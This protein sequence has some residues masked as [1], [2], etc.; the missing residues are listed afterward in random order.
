MDNI[1][2]VASEHNRKKEY[3]KEKD[4]RVALEAHFK[5]PYEEIYPAQYK[6]LKLVHTATS[7]LPGTPTVTRELLFKDGDYAARIVPTE[8]S[9]DNFSTT[10]SCLCNL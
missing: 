5:K 9:Q 10:F 8:E 3:E 2:T 1:T 6:Y 4:K 7:K